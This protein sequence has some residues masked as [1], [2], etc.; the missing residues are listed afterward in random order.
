MNLAQLV[1]SDNRGESVTH[2]MALTSREDQ[3]QPRVMPCGVIPSIS[4]P[5]NIYQHSN[6]PSYAH[7]RTDQA[8]LSPPEEEPIRCSLPPISTLLKGVDSILPDSEFKRHKHNLSGDREWNRRP[9]SHASTQAARYRTILPRTPLLR[10][11]SGFQDARH[12]P[13]ASSVSS[14]SISVAN[15]TA[16]STGD[17]KRHHFSAPS[18]SHHSS[19]LSLSQEGPYSTTVSQSHVPPFTSPIEPP[20]NASYTPLSVH[21]QQMGSAAMSPTAWQH[22]HYFPLSNASAYALNQGRHICQTC[23]KAFLR[24]ST[25]RIHSH[26]HT[27]EKPFRC[28]HVGCGK[29][30]SVRSNMKRHERGCHTGRATTSSTLVS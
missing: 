26:S 8:P 5:K 20:A 9:P 15:L 16:P 3:M 21:Q 13:A 12:S 17:P 18:Q 6:P 11:G 4:I 27:G 28:P 29:A 22:H 30:F 23:N 24:P 1:T 14:R 19:R 7:L 10:P 25:L 2:S